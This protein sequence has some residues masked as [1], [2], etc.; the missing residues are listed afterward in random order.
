MRVLAPS[1]LAVCCIAAD[2]P[3]LPVTSVVLYSSGV[4]YFEHAGGVDGAATAQLR[5]KTGQINDVIKSLVLQDLDGGKVGTVVFPSQD[6]LEK[7]LGSFQVDLRGNPS[8]GQLLGQLRG[9]PVVVTWQADKVSGTILGVENRT[10][11]LG[12]K[13]TVVVPVLSVATAD[14]IRQMPLD[15][16]GGVVLADPKL[17]AELTRALAAVSSAR[18]QDTK[19]VDL[20]FDGQGKRRVRVGYVVETPLWKISYRLVMPE[21]G[22]DQGQVQGWALVE[23]Q[24]DS[25]WN[26]VRLTLVSG[27]PVS[28]IQDLYRPLY[29]PRPV[30]EPELY[31]SLRPQSYAGGQAGA[32]ERGMDKAV[33][34]RDMRENQA[35]AGRAPAAPAPAM[36]MEAAVGDAVMNDV[37]GFD[38][39]SSVQSVAQAA[40]VGVLFQYAVPD[41]ALPRQRSAML[42]IITDPISVERV[43]IY[44]QGVQA[45]HPLNGAV[46]TNSTGKHLPAGPLTVFDGGAYAGDA[47]VGQLPPGERRLLSYAIDIPLTVDPQAVK[48]Q[49]AITTA[50]VVDGVLWTRNSHVAIQEY[51][52]TSSADAPRTVIVEHPRRGGWTLAEPAKPW[53][54]T[55]VL[56]RCRVAVPAGKEASLTVR[57]TR[58]DDEQFGIFDLQQE[59]LL[60][61]AGNGA[62]PAKV[63]TALQQAAQLKAQAAD[64]ERVRE[65]KQQELQ[66]IVQDQTRLR[67]NMQT[68]TQNSDYYRR[69]LTKLNDQETKVE[70]LQ[71]EIDRLQA[72]AEAKRRALAEYLRTLSVE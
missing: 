28:F 18:D 2:Q 10:K 53:E 12:D 31:A 14:G 70:A 71:T 39:A 60:W 22:K 34:K 56:Y 3:D 62:I 33:A 47:Q 5:F 44:N 65:Q 35:F 6:P 30:V 25:D 64:A 45:K 32:K 66:A 15:E 21:A 51:R 61:Y 49:S 72:D 17:Q 16:V 29:L 23:N 7:T 27:R 55:D 68:V 8:F 40:E 43:S 50:K 67:G 69:L 57:E 54:T 11:I 38:L 13:Q 20:R 19:P 41:V 24:T 37:V 9:A 58:V 59:S 42:P 1:L 36:A 46:V 52:F 4:G 48:E 26:N 63:R